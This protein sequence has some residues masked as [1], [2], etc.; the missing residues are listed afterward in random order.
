MK[1]FNKTRETVAREDTIFKGHIP[2]VRDNKVYN[3]SVSKDVERY[4]LYFCNEYPHYAYKD[5]ACTEKVTCDEMREMF[6][7]GAMAVSGYEPE[8]WINYV[9]ARDF[10]SELMPSEVR[11]EGVTVGVMVLNEWYTLFS[12]EY[13]E[14]PQDI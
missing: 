3:D 7:K 2:G 9:M 12:K 8:G 6:I 13:E 14:V 5:Q 11:E 4:V 10:C 1:M